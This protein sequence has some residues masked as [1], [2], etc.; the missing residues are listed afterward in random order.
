MKTAHDLV[1]EAKKE[2]QEV[3]LANATKWD[4]KAWQLLGSKRHLVTFEGHV[5][6]LFP[7]IMMKLLH[8]PKELVAQTEEDERVRAWWAKKPTYPVVVYKQ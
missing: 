7:M 2:I 6:K 5:K 4:P 3:P 1:A 8:M